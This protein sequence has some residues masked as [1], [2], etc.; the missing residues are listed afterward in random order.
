ML[1]A[2]AWNIA[3]YAA[4]VMMI[5]QVSDLKPGELV[6]VISDCHIYDRIS[7]L[8]RNLSWTPILPQVWNWI[9]HN[10]LFRLH[11]ESFIVTDY[12]HGESIGK[13]EVAV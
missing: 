9:N 5:A 7:P 10:R 4:L 13:Y 12:R 6:H 11:P 8:W 3:Q 1:A 2:N